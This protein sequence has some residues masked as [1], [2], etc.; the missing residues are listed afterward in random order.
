MSKSIKVHKPYVLFEEGDHRVVWLGLDESDAEKGVLANQ[1]LI[2]EGD[3]G[4]VLDAGGYFVFERVLGNMSEFVRPEKVKY[5]LFSHQDPD[6]VGALPMWL[7]ALPFCTPYVSVLWERFIP[8]LGVDVKRI[9]DIED[10]GSSV[11]LGRSTIKMLPAHFLHSPGNFHFYDSTSKFLFS[12]D[13]GAAIFPKGTW[14]LFV[15]DFEGH[16]P[17]M[18]WFHRRYVPTNRAIGRYLKYLEGLE[19]KT[20]APQ[21]GSVFRE[22]HVKRFL[23]WLSNVKGFLD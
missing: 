19:I 12:G 11:Q 10:E 18:E 5:L 4:A 23:T 21:H 17:L 3:Q 16:V 13:I 14:Y 1:Y 7:D 9:Q 8:H 20:I 2:Q 15:E 6:V 22:E